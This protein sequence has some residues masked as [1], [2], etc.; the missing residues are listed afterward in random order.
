MPITKSIMLFYREAFP[1]F[2][3][4]CGLCSDLPTLDVSCP[5]KIGRVSKLV[6]KVGYLTH[7]APFYYCH[8]RKKSLPG[9]RSS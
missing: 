2:L 1:V 8:R 3:S 5:M 9:K 6:Q 7:A 4:V